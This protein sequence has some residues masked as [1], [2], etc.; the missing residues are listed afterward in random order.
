MKCGSTQLIRWYTSLASEP[1]Y[2]LSRKIYDSNRGNEGNAFFLRIEKSRKETVNVSHQLK[3][4]GSGE[5]V[6]RWAQAMATASDVQPSASSLYLELALG[7]GLSAQFKL[8][9]WV[10]LWLQY[11]SVS[12]RIEERYYVKI[13]VWLSLNW[14]KLID[15]RSDTT[16]KTRALMPRLHSLCFCDKS[17]E[18]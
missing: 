3:T 11:L 10:E 1:D 17:S 16:L 9:S 4:S 8:F 13:M 18:Y 5:R 15:D 7:R 12:V 14:L 2:R 6:F